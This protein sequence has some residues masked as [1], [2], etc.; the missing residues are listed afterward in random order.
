MNVF[1]LFASISLDA[2]N[3][4][5]G[6][7]EAGNGVKKAGQTI[8]GGLKTAAKVGTVATAAVGAAAAVAGK[9]VINMANDTAAAGDA[10]DKNSQ[11]LGLSRKA[12][13]EWDYV[14]S[15]SGLDITSMTAGLKTMTKQVDKANKGSKDATANFQKLGISTNDLKTL[16]REE[17][18]EKSIK[19]L[20]GMKDNTER[21]ALANTLFGR[22]GVQLQPLLNSSAKSV[23]ELKKKANE[24]GFVMSDKAVNAARDYTDSMDTLKRT[25]AGVKN[26]IMSELLPSFKSIMD[27]FSGLLA[28]QKGAEGTFTKGVTSLVSSF[29]KVIP[30]F[31][32]IIMS[33]VKAVTKVAPSIISALVS[34]IIDN[35]PTLI[36][37]AISIVSALI[38]AIISAI[39]QL[40]SVLPT[41]ITGLLN[42]VSGIISQLPSMIQQLI[43]ALIQQL[44]TILQSILAQLPTIIN[45]LISLVL[46]IVN[47]LP[48]IFENLITALPTII[49]MVI[50]AFTDN[51]PLLIK[52]AIKLVIGLVKAAPKILLS[53]IEAIPDIIDAII[54]GFI[55]NIE[56]LILGAIQLVVELVKNMPRII[57]S[58]IKAIPKIVTSIVK[59]FTKLGGKFLD[60]GK[61]LVKG[62]WDGIAGMGKWLW[63]KVSGFFGGIV[64]KVKNFFGIKSPSKLFRDQIGKNLA[65]GIGVG[66]VD[67]MKN[68]SKQMQ[69]VMPTDF[70]FEEPDYEIF[71][72][73]TSGALA[74]QNFNVTINNPQVRK[75][76]DIDDIANKVS[77]TL[78]KM[79]RQRYVAYG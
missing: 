20:Q 35:L 77:D 24:L 65:K 54:D 48:T 34:G 72:T 22:S 40:V 36:N 3:F 60:I 11:K 49:R 58:L 31:T 51:L 27:G 57:L 39:P 38:S 2:K 61:N 46:G 21:A 59:A 75:D 68:V 18:F 56:T 26:R 52:G 73:G 63:D 67:E 15:Q 47:A 44:P 55:S 69:S 30:Q 12:Y 32:T 71:S 25:F 64:D 14:L 17:L 23:D 42:L 8:K 28:G 29:S 9:K 6:L 4:N 76:S 41:L 16:S 50:Q 37:S 1:E 62:I 43:T 45:G 5:Q 70:D 74:N 19:G 79:F 53:L 10:I 33:I 7:K 78:G 13:Q 66:F